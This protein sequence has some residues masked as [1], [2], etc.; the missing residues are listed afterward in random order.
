MWQHTHSPQSISTFTASYSAQNQVIG[1]QAQ[2]TAYPNNWVGCKTHP[3]QTT[4]MYSERTNDSTA[5]LKYG[6]EVNRGKWAYTAGA[7]GQLLQFDYTVQQPLGQH[8]PFNPDP[9]WTDSDSFARALLVGQSA[10]YAE[11]AGPIGTRLNAMLAIREETF[12]LTGA[13][14]F[15]PRASLAL[16]INERQTI[17]STYAQAFQ[18]AP[19]ID[20]L[21]Y[22]GNGLLR[23]PQVKQFSLG[24]GLW[25]T[26]WMTLSVEA[27][28]K[29]YSDEPVSTEYPGLMLANMVDMLGQ[30]FVWL[31]LK[32]EGRGRSEGIELLL[33]AHAADRFQIL[34]SASYSRT[35]YAAADGVLRPGN[36]DFPLVANGMVTLRLPLK[37][38]L[39]VRDTYASGRPYTP[40][41]IA[42]SEQQARGIYDLKQINAMRGPAYNRVDADVNRD[43]TLR[44]GLLNLHGGLENALDRQNFLGYAWE[45][46]CG[47]SVGAYCGLNVNAI[48]GVPETK[49]TQMPLF[50]S[51]GLRYRF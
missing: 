2:S 48:P 12:A 27:Y 46:S 38:Q 35:R 11:G 20:I 9:A 5:T 31:P 49:V 47:A 28:R 42:L 21:S 3:Y 15:E 36:F 23:P 16:R 26:D 43:F 33:R 50:P 24:A 30:Q 10:A 14:A 34:G 40:F 39:A 45:G 32:S 13:R 41:D 44:Y 29:L 19:S 22:P 37:L 7:T 6:F 18:S 8:S 4:L 25:R 17:N 1:Q 51:A